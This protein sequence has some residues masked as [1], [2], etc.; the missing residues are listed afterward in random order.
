MQNV[1]TIFSHL[2][3]ALPYSTLLKSSFF[4]L[5][6]YTADELESIILLT[7]KSL[8]KFKKE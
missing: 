8:R 6:P 1:L 4:V 2:Y 3:F 7:V 5:R